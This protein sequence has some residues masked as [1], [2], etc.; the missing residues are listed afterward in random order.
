M[1]VIFLVQFSG[2]VH[3]PLMSKLLENGHMMTCFTPRACLDMF[4]IKVKP[5]SEAC[6]APCF[7]VDSNIV[8]F[9]AQRLPD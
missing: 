5:D 7:L 3:F 1:G 4:L 6:P 2:F 9:F 8:F